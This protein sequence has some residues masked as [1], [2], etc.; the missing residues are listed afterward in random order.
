MVF[1][2]TF[3]KQSIFECSI[4]E[5]FAVASAPATI[6]WGSAI[7]GVFSAS[8]TPIGTCLKRSFLTRC[9]FRVL[10]TG[11]ASTMVGLA[12]QA[13]YNQG[14]DLIQFLYYSL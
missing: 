2:H 7:I 4:F 1:E 3:F 12:A 6:M 14:V 11:V 13:I 5:C 8:D 10:S 9:V